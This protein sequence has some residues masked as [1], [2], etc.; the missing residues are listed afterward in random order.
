MIKEKDDP[1]VIQ[2]FKDWL[3]WNEQP[4][5]KEDDPDYYYYTWGLQVWINAA[6]VYQKEGGQG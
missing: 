2:A 5:P 4:P 1:E 3:G 6:R